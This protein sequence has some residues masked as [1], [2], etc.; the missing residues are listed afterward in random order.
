VFYYKYRH[1]D[2]AL[3]RWP[4]RDPIGEKGG[5]NL[6]AFVGNDPIYWW[7]RLGL[8]PLIHGGRKCEEC[9]SCADLI[10]KGKWFATSIKTR[11]ERIIA[12]QLNGQSAVTYI[13]HQWQ[14]AMQMISLSNCIGYFVAHKPP[15]TGVM[16]P[17]I[18]WSDVPEWK[19]KKPYVYEPENPVVPI[20]V[21]I[22]VPIPV[23]KTYWEE[24]AERREA[25]NERLRQMWESGQIP[26]TPMGGAGKGALKLGSRAW[27]WAFP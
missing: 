27:K 11:I 22:P 1:Y 16:P 14:I 2:P 10:Q 23:E 6:Y 15:C 8:D 24:V 3:G 9:D 26:L 5:V 17:I 20:P 12:S 7:D 25:Q 4:S 13:G 18:P 21:L 19:P